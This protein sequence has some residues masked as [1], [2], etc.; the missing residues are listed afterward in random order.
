[1]N[2]TVIQFPTVRSRVW[3]DRVWMGLL[4]VGLALSGTI[5]VLGCW[6]LLR[7][8]IWIGLRLTQ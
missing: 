1:M 8:V 3:R 4:W 6:Q 2:A 7:A 5:A